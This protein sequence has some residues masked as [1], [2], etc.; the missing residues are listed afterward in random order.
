MSFGERLKNA[1][2]AK[3][4]SQEELA[5]I[6]GVSRQTVSDWERDE[7]MP[8]G[9]RIALLSKELEVSLDTLFADELIAANK[10][11]DSSTQMP[12][13]IISALE[14][15]ASATKAATAS[16]Q[17]GGTDDERKGQE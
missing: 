17:K 8:S 6:M 9:K 10:S 12:P 15:F 4:L 7:K 1:R 3:R 16:W 2:D 13:G 5:E 14:T 11:Q